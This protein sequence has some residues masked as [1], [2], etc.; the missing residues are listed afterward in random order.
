MAATNPQRDPEMSDERSRP[1]T[2]VTET[3]SK[4]RTWWPWIV[5]AIVVVVGPIIA[6]IALYHG[7]SYSTPSGGY[8]PSPGGTY[9]SP[10][11]GTGGGGGGYFFLLSR[12]ST[13]DLEPAPPE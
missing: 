7:G 1:M 4:R 6:Y 2:A 10:G 13:S 12:P 9:S 11:A 5:V 3:P 8:T